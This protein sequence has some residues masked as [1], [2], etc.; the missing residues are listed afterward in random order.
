[1]GVFYYVWQGTHGGRVLDITEI[2]KAPEPVRQWGG[3]GEFHWWGEPEHGYHRAEDPW[4][5]RRD[6]QMLTN[7]KVDFMF[8]D[9]TNAVT[10]LNVVDEVCRISEQMRSE[11][12]PTP[13]ICFLSNSNSGATMNKVFNQFYAQGKY[14]D[15][16]FF[17][18]GKP[19][20]MGH[21]DDPELLPHVKDFFTIKFSWAWTNS[22]TE[23]DHWQWLDRYP[24]DYGWSESPEIP[25]QVSVS[26]AHHPSNPLGKSYQNGVEPPVNEHYETEFTDHGLQFAE[27]WSRA[28]EV[29]PQL[30]MITQWNEWLAQRA[31]WD[32]GAGTYGGRPINNGDSYFVD[33]FSKEF[34]RDIAPMK[35]GYTDNYYYQM[36]SYI[37]QY[38]GME[39]SQDFSAP[40]SML[41]DGDFA[42]WDEVTP[43]YEDPV[44]DVIHRNYRGYDADTSYV[45][46]TGRNDILY[47]RVTYD[48]DSLYFYVETHK[49]MTPSS[50]T[51]WMLL[52]LDADRKLQTGWEGYDYLVRNNP[53]TPGISS[54]EILNGNQWANAGVVKY[55]VLGNQ[56]EFALIRSSV[57]M[58]QADPEFFFKWADNPMELSDV[59][60]FFMNGDAAPDRRF[61]F[62]FGST[63]PEPVPQTP[64]K[65]HQV[66][67]VI[68]FEDFD[69][70]DVGEAYVDTD[71]ANRGG[72]YRPGSSVDIGSGSEEINYVGWTQGGEWLEYTVN[73]NAIGTFRVAVD[74]ASETGG[75]KTLLLVDD[76]VVTDTILFEST[77]ALD[78]WAAK[79]DL[80]IQLSSGTKILRFQILEASDN[81][82][83]D[84][85]TIFAEEVVYPGEGE[86]LFRSLWTAKVG[87]RGWFEDS[88]C[89]EVDP[90]VE[91]SWDGSPGCGIDEQYW[92]A[93]WEGQLEPLFTE[94]YTI[95]LTMDDYGKVW[96]DNQLLIDA[97]KGGS[98]G[99]TYSATIELEAG[100]KVPIQVDVAQGVGAAN[101]SLE[102]E[103]DSNPREVIPQAQ[104]FQEILTGIREDQSSGA[105][106]MNI[107]ISRAEWRVI[108]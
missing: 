79:D 44:G 28:L 46:A 43:L 39:A 102:W 84:K 103:S 104:L 12:I 55:A 54:L 31:I 67:G 11:G 29:D 58:D 92:N 70:G 73:V 5:I 47:S 105:V 48:T 71:Q 40:K 45:N 10:Y 38:K 32:Q 72:A 15:L 56:M 66:P 42:E 7:A 26:V 81:L 88:I 93:R 34:N 80:L 68:E 86:G 64:Y 78:K 2:L 53:A 97:W 20:I 107:Q 6:L 76:K 24:Q 91:H 87:G 100:K 17:W 63:L 41:V 99:Q 89:G 77:G 60:T 52:L 82:N 50:D 65:D 3:V 1:M 74:F 96:V 18:Q 106:H 23:P 8:F 35:N 36:L 49:A 69:H 62:H 16:W 25:E 57:G 94:T 108:V 61:K 4:V 22:A 21:A 59:T 19:L 85:M 14:Q 90:F 83:L 30:V 51:L 75:Q 9:V 37:R 27:Q 101:I 98:Q 33:V 13:E 95:Y